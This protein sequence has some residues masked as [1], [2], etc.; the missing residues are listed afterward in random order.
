MD[1]VSEILERI[2]QTTHFRHRVL[3]SNV[4]NVDTPGY[5]AK[6]VKVQNAF[7]KELVELLSTNKF[8]MKLIS[9]RSG[10][11]SKIMT[12]TT[13]SWNDKNNVELD[14]EIAKMTENALLYQSSV[15]LLSTRFRMFKNAIR[16]R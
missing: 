1:K 11:R 12:E 2:L 5:K 6:D 14:L 4:A 13:P 10:V 16:G 9:G 8:H 3:A 7:K 15:K